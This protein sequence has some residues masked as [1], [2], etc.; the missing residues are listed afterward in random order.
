MYPIE[1]F[2]QSKN[3]KIAIDTPKSCSCGACTSHKN[4]YAKNSVKCLRKQE[5]SY[6]KVNS[7][8]SQLKDWQHYAL[9]E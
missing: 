6:L 4:W 8:D 2:E 7:I 1:E 9:G 3:F 5:Q